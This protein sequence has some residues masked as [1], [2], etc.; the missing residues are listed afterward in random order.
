MNIVN[1]KTIIIINMALVRKRGKEITVIG[2][3][4]AVIPK[5][6]VEL[7]T[8]L[9]MTSPTARSPFLDKA[10]LVSKT[11]SGSVV[12]IDTRKS[13]MRKK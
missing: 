12:P 7:Q 4:I 9:P 1:K 6:R 2:D 3:I 13:P 8:T 10:A 11:N 5:T